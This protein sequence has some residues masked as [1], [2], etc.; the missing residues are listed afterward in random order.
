MTEGDYKQ[1]ISWSK[2]AQG[3]NVQ[4]WNGLLIGTFYMEVD[5]Y[6]V[7]QPNVRGGYWPG[8]MLRALSDALEEL[9]KEWDEIVERELEQLSGGES[10]GAEVSVQARD[11]QAGAESFHGDE[12][13]DEQAEPR[14]ATRSGGAA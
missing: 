5:G 2:T 12:V 14:G 9:N 4:H 13:C 6:Y 8:Y 11:S 1:L 10:R 7:F 3:Y